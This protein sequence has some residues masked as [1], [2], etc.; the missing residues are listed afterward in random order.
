LTQHNN[1]IDKPLTLSLAVPPKSGKDALLQWCQQ[2]TASY[3]DVKVVD[4]HKSWRDG[5]AFC[6]LLHYFVPDDVDLERLRSETPLK[7]LEAIFDAFDDAGVPNILDPEDMLIEPYPDQLSVITYLSQVFHRFKHAPRGATA[8]SALADDAAALERQVADEQRRLAALEAAANQKLAEQREALRQRDAD[9]KAKFAQAELLVSSKIQEQRDALAVKKRE[10]LQTLGHSDAPRLHTLRKPKMGGRRAPTPGVRPGE[11]LQTHTDAPS[12]REDAT[13]DAAASA[14]PARAVAKPGGLAAANQGAL[15]AAAASMVSLKRT[16]GGGGGTASA[17]ERARLE[18]QRRR[19][20]DAA[21]AERESKSAADAAERDAK[22]KAEL[23]R[24]A[25]EAKAQSEREAAA[26]AREAAAREAE[27]EARELAAQISKNS[28][29]RKREIELKRQQA[30]EERAREQER[31]AAEAAR[32]ERE[33]IEKRRAELERQQREDSER[34]RREEEALRKQEEERMARDLDGAEDLAGVRQADGSILLP[35]GVQLPA[36]PGAGTKIRALFDYDSTAAGELSFKRGDVAIVIERGD[37]GAWWSAMLGDDV[38]LIP[39]NFFAEKGRRIAAPGEEELDLSDDDDDDSQSDVRREM[40]EFDREERLLEELE[41]K[42]L[43]ELA[44][45]RARRQEALLKAERDAEAA[46]AA[47]RGRLARERDELI[48][49]MQSDYAARANTVLAASSSPP[50]VGAGGEPLGAPI[51][52]DAQMQGFLNKRDG[53]GFGTIKKWRKRYYVLRDGQMIAYADKPLKGM[54]PTGVIALEFVERIEQEGKDAFVIVTSEKKYHLDALGDAA[55]AS[56][57][58]DVLHAAVNLAKNPPSTRGAGAAAA[59][60]DSDSMASAAWQ[61]KSGWL[62]KHG[63]GAFS[64]QWS[65]VWVVMKGGIVF[66]FAKP[67]AKQKDKVSLYRAALAEYKP[68]KYNGVTFTITPVAGENDKKAPT[69]IAFRAQSQEE[70]Q[71]WLNA[72]LRQ[73]I[74]IEESVDLISI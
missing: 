5:L 30:A 23:Q 10:R 22:A 69:E 27:R 55:A 28:E 32:R 74:K 71:G 16:G 1:N 26:R 24:V 53:R 60:G 3:S 25:A 61:R 14:S 63:G 45:E 50:S 65:K 46:A 20:L 40:A 47:E 41:R 7:R 2:K 51:E 42:K 64:A 33:A 4:F 9:E 36:L 54:A 66:T 62:E 11:K 12:T 39:S 29:E 35:N 43:D 49:K 31:A 52:Q 34:R 8:S 73:K 68:H 67:G 58:M 72:L 6:A 70:M 56:Q 57:W 37:A 18:A 44:A 48:N 15:A 38:G 19:E 17:E 59:P 13:S 21:R